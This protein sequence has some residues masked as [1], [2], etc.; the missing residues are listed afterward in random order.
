MDLI[1]PI[2]PYVPKHIFF[3][4]GILNSNDSALIGPFS[5][6]LQIANRIALAEFTIRIE[7]F[8]N[9]GVGYFFKDIDAAES[10]YI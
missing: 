7:T 9:G 8:V 5:F 3:V 10:A 2:I 1:F 4:A 6:K